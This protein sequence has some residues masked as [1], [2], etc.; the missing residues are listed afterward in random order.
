MLAVILMTSLLTEPVAALESAPHVKS[1]YAPVNGLK[2]Y[3]EIRGTADGKNPP[4]FL[5]HGGGSTIDTSFGK[6][7]PSLTKTRQVIAFEQQGH[8]RTA[9]IDRPSVY[10]RAVG[11]RH[12]RSTS[13]PQG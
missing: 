11:G 12:R 5:L 1:G 10:L 2:I 3:Y 9:D 7:L 6:V 4:L 13:I 8:G